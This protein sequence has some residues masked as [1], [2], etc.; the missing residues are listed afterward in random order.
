MS[1]FEQIFRTADVHGLYHGVSLPTSGEIPQ[2]I[3]STLHPVEQKIARTLQGKRKI[4]F[5]G[6]RVAA[7]L[8][9]KT[10]QQNHLGIDRDQMGAP[11]IENPHSTLTISITHKSDQ[12]IALINR[13]RFVT[14]G[15]DLEHLHPERFD[16]AKKVLTEKERQYLSTL[17]T[18]RQWCYLLMTF[19]FKEAIYKALAPKWKRYIGFEEAEVFPNV[20]MT[21]QVSLNPVKNDILPIELNARYIWYG[22]SII[23]S[24]TARWR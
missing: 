7:R 19:S 11:I 14:V 22:N 3:W 24:I 12:A 17:P 18:E 9:L 6:G 16:I 2:E 20:D 13:Q 21:A 15:V 8:A 4:S 23:T 10:I 5:V 1:S